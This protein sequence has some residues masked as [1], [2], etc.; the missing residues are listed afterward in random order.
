MANTAL[1]NNPEWI[2]SIKSAWTDVPLAVTV[3]LAADLSVTKQ[4][5]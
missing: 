2:S 5:V 4:T 1:Q 3:A